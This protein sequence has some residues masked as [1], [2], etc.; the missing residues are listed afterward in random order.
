MLKTV[1]D[2]FIYLGDIGT[3]SLNQT[4]DFIFQ[5]GRVPYCYTNVV[6]VFLNG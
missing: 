3:V 2:R 6:C 4:D 1:F 5:E